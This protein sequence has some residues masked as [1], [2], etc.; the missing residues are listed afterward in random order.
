[1]LHSRRK[2][3]I[4]RNLHKRCIRLIYNEKNSSYDELLTKDGS[5]SIQHRNILSLPT[6]LSKFEDGLSPKIYT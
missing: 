1:M 2:S 3:H 6:E 5:V 4:I